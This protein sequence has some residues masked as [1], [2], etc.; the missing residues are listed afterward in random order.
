MS[1]IDIICDFLSKSS[2]ILIFLNIDE[3]E[4]L[5]LSINLSDCLYLSD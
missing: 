5:M 4:S 3:F 1:Q 2:F